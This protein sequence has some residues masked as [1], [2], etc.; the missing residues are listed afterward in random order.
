MRQH[1]LFEGV[2]SEFGLVGNSPQ[3]QNVLRI[4]HRLRKNT[5]PVLITG[6]SGAGKELVA[7][8]AHEVSPLAGNVFLPVDAAT[9]SGSLLET[10]LFGHVKGAFTGAIENKKGLVRA[11]DGGTLFLDEIGE[12]SL[13]V[14]A[15]L[16]RLLQEQEIRPIGGTQPIKVNVRVLAATNRDLDAAVKE[17]K[18]RRDLYYRLKVVT[19][20]LPPLRERKSD[21]PLLI[22]RFVD[23]YAQDHFHLS[24]AV[25]DC[26]MRYNWPG[27]V[28]EL[29][30]TI[31]GVVALKSSPAVYL[32]D[33]PS[34]LRQSDSLGAAHDPEDNPEAILPLEEVERRHIL[35]VIEH[36]QG[37]LN[38]AARFL[39]IS[40][41]TI[42]R[43]LK[44][45]RARGADGNDPQGRLFP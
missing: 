3:I 30:N 5:S 33:L 43:K 37:D 11:A 10:E 31:R 29:E 25:M 26:F 19:I 36:T 35:K 7:R 45:Y 41:T 17:G 15:K 14:Q 13:E 32:S 18:F 4:I 28:R 42:Y 39:G 6:E 8:A 16:L 24:D 9:L 44:Q 2:A 12:L 34:N 38:A 21:I 27:N 40:R 23:K 20:R 22:Q 1:T